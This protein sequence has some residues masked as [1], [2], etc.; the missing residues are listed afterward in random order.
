MGYILEGEQLGKSADAFVILLNI[1]K[2]SPSCGLNHFEFPLAIYKMH[3][4]TVYYQTSDFFFSILG[5][6]ISISA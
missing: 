4:L 2:Y 6:K 5:V 1:R 3:L